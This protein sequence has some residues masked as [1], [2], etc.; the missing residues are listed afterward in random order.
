MLKHSGKFT[1][2]VYLAQI[3]KT[4]MQ[5][6]I[7]QEFNKISPWKNQKYLLAFSG[8]IDSVVLA[9]VLHQLN[10]DFALAHCNFKLRGIES[11]K[12]Q[13][14]VENFARQNHIPLFVKTCD[15][16]QTTENTQLTARNARYDW[17]KQLK[18]QHSFDYILTAHHL[19]DSIETFFINLLRGTGLNGLTGIQ[20]GDHIF[21][22]MLS[23]SRKEIEDF[24]R[25]HRLQW[26]EDSSNASDKYRRNFIRHQIIPVL[27]KLQ[28]EFAGV[29]QKNFSFLQQSQAVVQDWFLQNYKTLIK[30]NNKTQVI[31]LQQFDEINQKELFLFQWLSKYGFSDWK[32]I[33]NL[34]QSQTGKYILSENYR[35]Y[36]HQNNLILEPLTPPQNKVYWI[37]KN[38]SKMNHPIALTFE[39]LNFE[40]VK[41]K[42]QKA[43]VSEAYFDYDRLSFPLR[44]RK[45]QDGDYFFPLGM[46]GKKK[47]S[48]Y[49][50]DEKMR[51]SEKEKIWLICDSRNNI[52]WV[53]G[54]RMDNRYKITDKTKHV[55]HIKIH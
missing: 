10:L 51:L 23:V 14:F 24:A 15:L 17:F 50:K 9:F 47:L 3:L 43:D 19:N 18:I 49:F 34:L 33:E 40:K 2:F 30:I 26:R 39:K 8:G 1:F 25:Q 29:M 46:K 27:E 21:R 12:D 7:E 22:P 37:A 53:A 45:W 42:Y 20:S 13:F 5:A 54:K 16:S 55:L 38:Q 31:D 36:K 28:P 6:K 52:I 11:D 4:D 35:L 32:S 41:T 48:D 44:L